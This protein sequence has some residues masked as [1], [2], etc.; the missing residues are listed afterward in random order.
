MVAGSCGLSRLRRISLS[1]ALVELHD[2]HVSAVAV[3]L[4]FC[5]FRFEC[6]HFFARELDF[7]RGEIFLNPLHC[8]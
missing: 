4:D 8:S 7:A 2:V 1:F 5:E 3:D 6:G